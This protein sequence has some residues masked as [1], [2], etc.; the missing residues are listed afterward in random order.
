MAKVLP[1]PSA[2]A[3]EETRASEAMRLRVYRQ[4]RHRIILQQ[5]TPGSRLREAEWTQ[6]LGVNR[7]ALREAFV[8]LE[9]EGLIE[10]GPKTGYFVPKLTKANI[11][12][13]IAVRAMLETGA[14]EILCQTG[15]N[16]PQ[17]LTAMQAA[18]DRLASIDADGNLVEV[19]EADWEFHDALIDAAGNKRLK[20]VYGHA[21][22]PL[23]VPEVTRGPE[24]TARVQQTVREHRA[25]L[26]AILDGDCSRGS[27]L[28]R[29]HIYG[30]SL[31]AA[32]RLPH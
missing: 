20:A 19:A 7:S 23:I 26:Q 29:E 24:W 5:V 28:L 16:T 13:V 1:K 30:R 3:V 8:R 31:E 10:A 12:E 6:R 25:V 18:C 4:L 22:L 32:N 21:P 27:Q 15:K 2:D 11:R 17:R 9:A 14:I